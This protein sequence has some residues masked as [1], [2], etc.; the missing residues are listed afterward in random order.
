MKKVLL[1]TC[2]AIHPL[3]TYAMSVETA[4]VSIIH[5]CKN[6]DLYNKA[7]KESNK[8]DIKTLECYCAAF[9]DL[10]ESEILEKVELAWDYGIPQYDI[11]MKTAEAIKCSESN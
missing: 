3:A 8:S 5:T 2:L 11:A 1:I 4:F 6:K 9:K 10:S 7:K